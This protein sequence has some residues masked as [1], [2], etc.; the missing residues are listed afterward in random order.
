[1]SATLADPVRMIQMGAPHLISSDE[2]LESYTNALF[3]LT[4]KEEPTVDEI[5]A[6]NLL[7]MLVERYEAERFPIPDVS[8]HDMLRY[9]MDLKQVPPHDLIPL[10]GGE[11][12][13]SM[14][15][16]GTQT[17]T[18]GN[19]AALSSFFRVSPAVFIPAKASS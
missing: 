10:L 1:M 9:L 8:A 12:T 14:I 13:A 15:L 2:D 7:S 6:I 18:I 17:L 19:V 4:A 11:P 5:E 16:N 3:D